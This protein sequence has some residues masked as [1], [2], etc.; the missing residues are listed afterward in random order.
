LAQAFC[1]IKIVDLTPVPLNQKLGPD[2]QAFSSYVEPRVE[3]IAEALKG[4]DGLTLGGDVPANIWPVEAVQGSQEAVPMDWEPL[5]PI[6]TK[7]AHSYL[8]GVRF[9]RDAPRL[10]IVTQTGYMI[11]ALARIIIL[12]AHLVTPP[13][14]EQQRSEMGPIDAIKLAAGVMESVLVVPM[15]ACGKSSLATKVRRFTRDSMTHCTYAP[16][17][18]RRVFVVQL[19]SPKSRTL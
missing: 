1:T 13:D 14:G 16:T 9:I 12:V 11:A 15:L 6:Q 7:Q 19:A 5:G 3:D 18:S 17:V 4:V 8:R 10:D 2:P